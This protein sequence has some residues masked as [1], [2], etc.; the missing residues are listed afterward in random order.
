MSKSIEVKIL[1][2]ENLTKSFIKNHEFSVRCA[3]SSNYEIQIR[4]G[5]YVHETEVHRERNVLSHMNFYF[6]FLL[7]LVFLLY[8]WFDHLKYFDCNSV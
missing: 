3:T 7:I 1:L 2:Y 5:L 6:N 8:F 4:C